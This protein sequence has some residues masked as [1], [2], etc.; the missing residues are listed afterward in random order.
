M[1]NMILVQESDV[2]RMILISND[3]L[4]KVINALQCIALWQREMIRNMMHR[5]IRV[6]KTIVP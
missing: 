4:A 6:V 5:S 2:L 1:G 3:N